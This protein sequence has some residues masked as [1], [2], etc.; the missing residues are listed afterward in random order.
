MLV[1]LAVDRAR[2]QKL[3]VRA[4]RREPAVVEDDELVGEREG[5]DRCAMMIVVRPAIASRSPVRIRASVVAST[6]AVAS[7]R[8][9]TRGSRINARAIAI[10]CRWPPRA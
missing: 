6:L 9:S 8:I 5:R 7:S 4:A 1:D 2:P 3:L 10:R